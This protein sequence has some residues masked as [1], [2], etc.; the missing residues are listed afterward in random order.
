MIELVWL[1]IRYEIVHI[2]YIVMFL[3]TNEVDKEELI[4]L[5]I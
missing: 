5:K 3:M 4:L 1:F 2:L